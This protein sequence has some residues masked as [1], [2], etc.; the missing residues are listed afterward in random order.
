MD[1]IGKYA[2][3]STTCLLEY[4]MQT[5]KWEKYKQGRQS[6]EGSGSP[7]KQDVSPSPWKP[8]GHLK[9]SH[10]HF[11][12]I[13][14]KDIAQLNKLW[15]SLFVLTL[16]N[17]LQL[18]KSS[19]PS[20]D[21]TQEAYLWHSLEEERKFNQIHCQWWGRFSF[22]WPHRWLPCQELGSSKDSS[23]QILS[24]PKRI[25]IVA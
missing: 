23:P 19:A 4:H 24:P 1:V 21:M 6:C 8:S 3:V 5:K 14:S 12:I 20:K 16:S 7:G 25:C 10:F 15:V 13:G 18:A 2:G 17:Y 11:S 9:M 22:T